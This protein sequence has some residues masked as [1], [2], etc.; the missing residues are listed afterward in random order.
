MAGEAGFVEHSG[1]YL[2]PDEGLVFIAQP[3]GAEQRA[4]YTAWVRGR[5]PG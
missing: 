1:I 5:D 2:G 3:R 4:G